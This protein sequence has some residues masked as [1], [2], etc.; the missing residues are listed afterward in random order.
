VVAA[1]LV[2]A[3]LGAGINLVFAGA[4]PSTKVFRFQGP[5]VVGANNG[6]TGLMDP[7]VGGVFVGLII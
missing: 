7:S 3:S 1:N 6:F 2:K 4:S 5:G